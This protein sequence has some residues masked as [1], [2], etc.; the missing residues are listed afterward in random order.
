MDGKQ[1]ES[2]REIMAESGIDGLR[3][4]FSFQ[5]S[6]I[7]ANQFLSFPGL[8]PETVVG[9]PIKPGRETRFAPEAP[10]ILVG[11][12]KGLLGEVVRERDIGPDQLPKQTS[13]T[14]LMIPDQLRES[15]VVVINKNARNEI[16]I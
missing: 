16:C 14:R 11:P 2:A 5:L 3:I 4:L 9:N 13:H 6:F 7:N 15:V 10:Q 1:F 12:E 8:F